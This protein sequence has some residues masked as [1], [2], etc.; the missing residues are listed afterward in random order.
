M[1]QLKVKNITN[2]KNLK[3]V[4]DDTESGKLSAT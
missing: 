2:Q 4:D 3:S 1:H